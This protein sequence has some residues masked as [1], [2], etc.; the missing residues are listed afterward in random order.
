MRGFF[1]ETTSGGFPN[2]SLFGSTVDTCFRQFTEALGFSCCF[3]PRSSSTAVVWLVLLGSNAPRA[4][5]ALHVV[6]YSFVGR[7]KIFGITV[8]V[9]R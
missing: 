7:P 2:S 1:W 3:M 4:V 9:D 6:F 8:D 5:L